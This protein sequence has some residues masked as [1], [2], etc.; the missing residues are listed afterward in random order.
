V[1]HKHWS[2]KTEEVLYYVSSN[3][4]MESLYES[5]LQA[6]KIETTR[7]QGAIN[8]W[9]DEGRNPQTRPPLA[10]STI[11]S[12]LRPKR[13]AVIEYWEGSG[14]GYKREGVDPPT[15]RITILKRPE[16]PAGTNRRMALL[17]GELEMGHEFR[18]GRLVPIEPDGS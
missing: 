3:E 2:D 13:K 12:K 11:R 15:K 8:R 18:E 7:R 6:H 17:T 4:E 1:H 16:H 14:Y 9:Q 10:Y 5:L